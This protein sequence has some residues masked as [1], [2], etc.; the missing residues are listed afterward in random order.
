MARL[1]MKDGKLFTVKAAP[2]GKPLAWT[3][4]PREQ[5]EEANMSLAPQV[6]PLA[7]VEERLLPGRR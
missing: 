2:P 1:F 5:A 7:P 3:A 6:Q 4:P